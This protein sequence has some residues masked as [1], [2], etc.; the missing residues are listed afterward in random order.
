[1]EFELTFPSNFTFSIYLCGLQVR[2]C[3]RSFLL[4]SKG[5]FFA[6]TGV[7]VKGNL[8]R[9]YGK[10]K[11]MKAARWG[12]KL[13]LWYIYSI[14]S[15]W[16]LIKFLDLENGRLFEA[17]RLLNFHHFQQVVSLFCKKTNNNKA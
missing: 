11:Q 8:L 16:A 6:K 12:A 5:Y 3:F 7:S 15:P 4:I 17:G 9:A 13:N 10:I 14:K 1:M 2:T